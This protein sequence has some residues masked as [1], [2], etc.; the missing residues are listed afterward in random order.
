M[1]G[2]SNDSRGPD[3]HAADRFAVDPSARILDSLAIFAAVVTPQASVSYV[4]QASLSAASMRLEDVLGLPLWL[5]PW[6][7]LEEPVQA[8]VRLA[9][10]RA[11]QGE[12]AREDIP[13]WGPGKD[14][15]TAELSVAPVLDAAGSVL[16]LIVSAVDVS[17]QRKEARAS[18]DR[19]RRKDEFLAMLAHELRNPLAP[20]RHAA[21]LMR[22]G[23]EGHAQ[24]SAISALVD[25][26]VQQMA[27]LL[28]DL[29]DASRIDQ[30]KI[31]LTLEP[32]ELGNLLTQTID[33]TRSVT[34]SRA[35]RV[36]LSLP[37]QETWLQADPVRITQ[38][39]ENLVTNA[40][41]FTDTEGTIRVTLTAA[42]AY[43]TLSVADNGQ[44]IDAELL[45]KVFDLFTQG[46]RSLDRSQ[47]GLGI[48]LSL[49][50]NLAELHGGE[51][52]AH[53]A[54]PGCGSEFIV[55]LPL[56][57]QVF[58][59]SPPVPVQVGF[60]PKRILVVDDNVDAAE[61]LAELL[62]LKGHETRA[63]T[64]PRTALDVAPDFSPQVILLDI[65]L[66]D[67]DGF[68]VARRL[69]QMA[70]TRDSL[71]VAVTG[72]GQAEDRKASAAAGFDHHLVKPVNLR[73]LE[74]LIDRR[75]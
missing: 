32:V 74:D 39:I 12:S 67:I 26:Q 64:D 50:R 31:S 22:L 42:D 56:A 2:S 72:Y 48:G 40:A 28:D 8:Q 19:N 37:P 70:Q 55:T 13:M 1:G 21:A 14:R 36:L 59:P 66:P 49:V 15:I 60:S 68:Q 29:L 10:E 69:R 47:G 45:P 75:A 9:C 23:D 16:R 54:G 41:K 20:L 3:E 71:L 51:V 34:D 4:N 24:R 25:R 53:S 43:A 44:G 33:G 62:M 30:G 61:S 57:R 58:P 35:Q 5:T 27:R 73:Q 65:G 17:A 11:A 6:W 7:R 46:A 18:V 63:V 52:T 38:I